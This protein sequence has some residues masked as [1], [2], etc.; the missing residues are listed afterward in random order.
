MI[1][2][3]LK[4]IGST[5]AFNRQINVHHIR[6]KPRYR[7]GKGESAEQLID[8]LGV[9]EGVESLEKKEIW[10]YNGMIGYEGNECTKKLAY[11]KGLHIILEDNEIVE[12]TCK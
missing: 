3:L 11:N 8:S 6:T 12:W 9:P 4:E 5:L 1:R 7:G 10:E 2:N